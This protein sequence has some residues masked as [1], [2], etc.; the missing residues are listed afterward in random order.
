[1]TSFKIYNSRY[2]GIGQQPGEW[3]HGRIFRPG[4][5]TLKN[6]A[7]MNFR[8]FGVDDRTF[9][10]GRKCARKAFSVWLMAHRAVGLI[11]DSAVRQSC[12]DFSCCAR[13]GSTTLRRRVIAPSRWHELLLDDGELYLLQRKQVCHKVF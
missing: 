12:V 2:L 8:I 4:V 5:I 11:E 1:M 6:R 9:L 3:L 7:D 13:R 10:Q